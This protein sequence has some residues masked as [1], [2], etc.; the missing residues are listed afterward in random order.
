VVEGL[1]QRYEPDLARLWG[2]RMMPAN[3]VLFQIVPEQVRSW[4]L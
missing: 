1:L 4:G 3:R 2:G